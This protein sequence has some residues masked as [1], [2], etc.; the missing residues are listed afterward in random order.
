MSPF[1]LWSLCW[2][3]FWGIL[4]ELPSFFFSVNRISSNSCLLLRSKKSFCFLHFFMA[5][6][7]A[8]SL[9][10]WLHKKTSFRSNINSTGTRGKVKYVPQLKDSLTEN[11]WTEKTEDQA[12]LLIQEVAVKQRKRCGLSCGMLPENLQVKKSIYKQ[13]PEAEN[14]LLNSCIY[15]KILHLVYEGLYFIPASAFTRVLLQIWY[16]PA[17][18][19]LNDI[20]WAQKQ[21][22]FSRGKKHRHIFMAYVN[23]IKR[24]QT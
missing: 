5:A 18:G 16:I 23:A 6:M 10:R 14:Q 8:L 21:T 9:P 4:T 15:S 1:L 13:H 19:N 12:Q 7:S 22:V 20:H 17:L 2:R 3:G 24:S 11:I